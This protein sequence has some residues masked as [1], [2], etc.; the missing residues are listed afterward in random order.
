MHLIKRHSK[1]PEKHASLTWQSRSYA[2]IILQPQGY[3]EPGAHVHVPARAASGACLFL[4]SY[5]I[6]CFRA[7]I[8]QY[9][10]QGKL[11]AT[12]FAVTKQTK[13]KTVSSLRK[14]NSTRRWT[15]LW[16]C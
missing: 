8:S 16:R 14:H 10:I 1:Y 11:T 12:I 13:P 5:S 2:V 4:S 3:L 15:P 6:L 9:R 7:K